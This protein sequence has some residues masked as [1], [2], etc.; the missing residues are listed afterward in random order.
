MKDDMRRLD[1]CDTEIIRIGGSARKTLIEEEKSRILIKVLRTLS[2]ATR[3]QRMSGKRLAPPSHV[4]INTVVLSLKLFWNE[5]S[6]VNAQFGHTNMLEE[7]TPWPTQSFL[8]NA[9]LGAANKMWR[10]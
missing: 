2:S 1:S 8:V 7:P 10:F 4:F 5:A 6:L 3:W 9:K